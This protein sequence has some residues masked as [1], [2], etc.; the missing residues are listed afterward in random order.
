MGEYKSKTMKFVEKEQPWK[1]VEKVDVALPSATQNEICKD[2]AL[3][4]VKAGCQYVGEG[5]NMPST[6]D[7]IEVFKKNCKV[8]IP[9][10][11]ANAGGVAVSG[12]EMA[13]NSSRI[14][15]SRKEVDEKLYNIMQHIY[16]ECMSAAADLGNKGDFQLG[17]NAAGFKKV[18]D[19]MLA[20]GMVLNH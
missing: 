7:A 14:E 20:Q 17:A 16:D 4:L 9:A 19:A 1:Y 10:K 12:L 18:A 3:A 5:A 15:W 2:D 13:Q 11:A 8:F 6:P